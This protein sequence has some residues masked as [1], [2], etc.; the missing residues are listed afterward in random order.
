M[1]GDDIKQVIIVRADLE[2]SKG[3]LGAQ[4]AHGSVSSYLAVSSR[5]KEI[6][7]EWLDSGQ[8]KIVLKVPDEESLLKLFK[9]Y[10]FKKIPCSLINDAG[11]TQLPPGTTTVL[12]VG[13]WKSDEID[14][15][16]KGLKLL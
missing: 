14:Q 5:D 13:P 3:K 16:S 1:K 10:Q 4:I 2:M 6:A 7:K 8:K 15:F 9:A 11:L 12:G